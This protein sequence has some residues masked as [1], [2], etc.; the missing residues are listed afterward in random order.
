MPA[1]LS[2]AVFCEDLHRL[3]AKVH[4]AGIRVLFSLG[5]LPG[6]SEHETGIAPQ[7]FVVVQS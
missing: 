4:A 5:E 2:D 3:F 7:S 1:W 6:R